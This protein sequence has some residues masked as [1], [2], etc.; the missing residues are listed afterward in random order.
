MTGI[1][2][3]ASVAPE[4]IANGYRPLPLPPRSKRPALPDWT[5][6]DASKHPNLAEFVDAGTGLLCGHGVNAFD[7][8]VRHPAAASALREMLLPLFAG[9]PQRIGM[10]PKFC[11]FAQAPVGMAKI[12]GRQ[13]LFPG[14]AS[15][16][17]VEVLGLGQ[18]VVLWG[19]HPDTGLPYTWPECDLRE[20]P[21]ASLPKYSADELRALVKKCEDIII[22]HGG[23]PI[24]AGD[25]VHATDGPL[26][27]DEGTLRDLRDALSF[28]RADDRK[29]W[30]D[31]GYAL[32][33]LGDA[34]RG[35][36]FA[37]SQTSDKYD[38]VA[39]RQM[40][41]AI[42]PSKTHFRAVFTEAQANWHWPNPLGKVAG[43]VAG[44][45][46]KSGPAAAGGFSFVQVSELLAQPAPVKWLI[47]ELLEEGSMAQLFGQSGGGKSFLA[48]DWATTIATGGVWHDRP[49]R[50]G[51]VFYIAG[52]GH[53]GIGRRLRAWELHH[54]VQLTGAP[55]FV[56]K[57]PAQ[58]LDAVNAMAVA[59]AAR[60]LAD[61]H[62]KPALVVVDTLHRNFGA[63]DE[64][65]AADLGKFIGNL[66][67]LLRLPLGCAVLIVHHVGHLA[68]DRARGSSSIRA[69]MDHEYRL[70]GTE[71][72]RTLVCTKNK[73]GEPVRPQTFE[74]QQV[75][76][77]GWEDAD[78][79]VPTS[80]VLVTSDAPRKEAKPV[81]RDIAMQALIEAISEYGQKMPGTSTIPPGV[82]AVNLE[83]WLDRWVLRTGYD[84][85]NTH[86]VRSNFSKDQKR[87]LEDG[88]IAISKP[89]VWLVLHRTE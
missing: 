48:I 25:D 36:W 85:D 24:S 13:F 27:A 29:L 70:D 15:P 4:L 17:K 8:D 75:P 10:A 65:S 47:H 37:W 55:L 61:A 49:T 16:H 60:Q 79:V 89:Y 9:S 28:I 11:L 72:P 39:A 38:P 54:Q 59:A 66:D 20:V 56:S 76:L 52:E 68:T 87:L 82:K 18:Q 34:G 7:V 44:D 58:L 43:Q 57:T 2:P 1:P 67:A 14:D 45:N 78:G 46:T 51:S 73:E 86:S 41:E 77:D 83:Q 88:R 80:A 32:K 69:A 40:W 19:V 23:V 50:P 64:N 71:G 12:N 35:L 26:Y 21:L 22:A 3:F 63:G 74:L 30:Q 42:K 31:M 5:H 84:A 81:R 62:G 6:F 33:T 53:R